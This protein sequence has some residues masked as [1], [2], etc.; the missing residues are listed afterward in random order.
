[1]AARRQ[2]TLYACGFIN[3]A[4]LIANYNVDHRPALGDQTVQLDTWYLFGLGPQAIPAIDRLL[5]DRAYGSN[6]YFTQERDRQVQE[7]KRR[8]SDWRAWTFR[9]WRLMRYLDGHPSVFDE[10]LKER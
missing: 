8:M 3:F 2:S 1:L 5:A 9:D 6:E 10:G 7:L 4:A